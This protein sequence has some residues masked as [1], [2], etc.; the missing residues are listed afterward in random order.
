MLIAM[1]KMTVLIVE[2]YEHIREL[3]TDALTDAGFEVRKAKDGSEGVE[4]ALK[5]HPDVIMMD[6]LMPVMNGHEAV[7]KIRKDTWGHDARIIYLTN[8]SDPQDVVQAIEQGPEEYIVKENTS[9]KEIV[10]QVRLAAR[11]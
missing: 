10:N 9:I 6:I 3:Y 2:D 4:M 7:R 11:L 1:K 5:H 8:L